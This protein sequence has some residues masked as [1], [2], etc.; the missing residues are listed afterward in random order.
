MAFWRPIVYLVDTLLCWWLLS[1][2]GVVKERDFQNHCR[3]PWVQHMACTTYCISLFI[4]SSHPA[5]TSAEAI[6]HD[7]H[8]ACYCFGSHA[9][10]LGQ[11]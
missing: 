2:Q 9:A 6:Q 8:A 7:P 10:W 5:I 1:A 4:H 11:H 3:R